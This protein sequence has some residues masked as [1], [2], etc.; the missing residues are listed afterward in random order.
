[1]TTT[2]DAQE[3]AMSELTDGMR[4][5]ALVAETLTRHARPRWWQRRRPLPFDFVP[6]AREVVG[7]LISAGYIDRSARAAAGSATPTED[8]GALD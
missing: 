1:M 3:Q 2:R 6:V 5:V 7:A 4:A 8:D